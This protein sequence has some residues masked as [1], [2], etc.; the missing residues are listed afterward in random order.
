MR[1]MRD[2][3]VRAIPTPNGYVEVVIYLYPRMGRGRNQ[4]KRKDNTEQTKRKRRISL[5]TKK[6]NNCSTESRV[7]E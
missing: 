7:Y 2:T 4:S 5:T 6:K 1:V 3:V